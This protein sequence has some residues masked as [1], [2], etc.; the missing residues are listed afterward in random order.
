MYGAP[1]YGEADEWVWR[2]AWRSVNA[3][4]NAA[5]IVVGIVVKMPVQP[6]YED[7]HD[8][9]VCIQRHKVFSWEAWAGPEA[10]RFFIVRPA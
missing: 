4:R 7:A 5:V 8:I 6:D 3:W 9:L 2:A 10:A 1:M